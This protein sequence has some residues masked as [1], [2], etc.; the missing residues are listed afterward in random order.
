MAYKRDRG[1]PH[2]TGGFADVPDAKWSATSIFR[3]LNDET[4][5]GTLVQGK[6][7]THNYKIKDIIH[8]PK[9]EWKRTEGA[10]EAIINPHDYDLAQRI[11]KLD[12]R[13]AP[14]GD[15]VYLFSGVLICGCCGARMTRK[16]N[17]YKG[18]EYFY[19]YCPTGKKHG[20][21]H[22]AMMKESDLAACV[23]ESIKVHVASIAS[24][25]SIIATSDSQRTAELLAHQITSQITDVEKQLATNASLN[26]SLYETMVG[27]L[28]SKEDYKSLKSRYTSEE[29]R[30]REAIAML[31]TERENALDGK[32]ERLRWMEHFTQFEAITELDRRI[33][34]NLIQNVRI[35]G[36]KSME[37]TF[38]YHDEY[39]QALNLLHCGEV[40]A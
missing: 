35:T 22:A 27:G 18:N 31:E 4:Y 28:L 19:Y 14:G 2:P 39:E 1:L 33:V 17:R 38:N 12:T 26:K 10:H 34:V 5:T 29:S 3:I 6:I 25:D 11:M 23:L 13:S 8:R 24:L 30:L 20:C 36:K 21:Q 9:D 32:A 7:Y 16:T 37:I 15:K 40:A